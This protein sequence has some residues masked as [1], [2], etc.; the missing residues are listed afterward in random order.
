MKV[1]SKITDGEKHIINDAV[2]STFP[3]GVDNRIIFYGSMEWIRLYMGIRIA[4]TKLNLEILYP[5][6]TECFI[7]AKKVRGAYRTPFTQEDLLY[8]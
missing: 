1:F 3:K 6:Y 4:N 8:L 2:F 7:S 5:V